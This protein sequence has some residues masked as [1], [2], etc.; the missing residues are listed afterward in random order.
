MASVA[1]TDVSEFTEEKDVQR[2]AT[3]AGVAM[4][5]K[6]AGRAVRLLGDV[7]L[8]RLLGPA[9][10]GLYAIGWSVT[11]ILT[12]FTPLG[13]NT[14]V[15][16]FGT[17]FY[18]QD[19][20]RLKGVLVQS[21]WIA[22]PVG[23]LAGAGLY[24]AAPW[25][26][27]GIFHSAELTPVLQCFAF[28]FPLITLLRVGAASTRISQRMQ[29]S[30]LAEDVSQP[31]SD[32]LLILL[33]WVWGYR[34]MGALAALVFSFGISLV[35]CFF[36]VGKLFP[37]LSSRPTR[38][39]FP[40]KELVT[41]SLPASFAGAFGVMLIWVD[42]IL[43]GLFR[44]PAEVGVYNAVSQLGVAMAIALGGLGAIFSPLAAD[45]YHRR[46]MRR[47]QE[48]FRVNTKW[49]LYF[50]L[51]LFLIVCFSPR[52]VMTVIF[53]NSYAA[54]WVPLII[55]GAAQ[56][57]NAATGSVGVL[58]VMTGN[59]TRIFALSG[60]MVMLSIAMGVVFIPRWG[61]LGA[62]LATSCAISGLFVSAVFLARSRLNIWPYDRRH[63]KGLLAA[64]ASTGVLFL[65]RIFHPS[66][67]VLNLAATALIAIGIFVITLGLLG[68]DSEDREM[69]NL[70]R[71]RLR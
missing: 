20:S 29:F 19:D 58:L 49:A 35:L 33:F 5:G 65:F 30:V 31:V 10:F 44:P 55:L 24:A 45:L 46:E 32:L 41:F 28:A 70:I 36:W 42:R 54:G 22:L 48:V 37:Q 26:G 68:I 21:L 71:A 13:L 8:A 62:A 17:R 23:L 18:H 53:G 12:L 59:Q 11:R 3:G 51:P 40:G 56:L 15:V 67:P 6:L 27:E 47:L 39:V 60:V 52:E 43:L 4:G 16:Q 57:V 69:I 50:G 66:S 63:L 9:S 2:L 7:V 25:L 61:M 64:S 38:A 34:L 14:G 1:P